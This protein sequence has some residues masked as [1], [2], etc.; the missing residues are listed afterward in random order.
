MDVFEGLGY[1]V[2]C[3]DMTPHEYGAGQS[4]PRMYVMIIRRVHGVGRVPGVRDPSPSMS[5]CISAMRLPPRDL[6]SFVFRNDDPRVTRWTVKHTQAPRTKLEENLGRCVGS[7]RR[8]QSTPVP[9]QV[10]RSDTRTRWLEQHCALYQEAGLPWPGTMN[11]PTVAQYFASPESMESF[12]VLT[13]RE[14]DAL[15]YLVARRKLQDLD[16]GCTGSEAMVDLY[17]SLARVLKWRVGISPCVLPHSN[18]WIL[19]ARR[20]ASPEEALLLQDFDLEAF[21]IVPVP[22]AEGKRRKRK[23]PESAGAAGSTGSAGSEEQTQTHEWGRR[24]LFDLAGNAFNGSCV[25][26]CL[27]TLLAHAGSLE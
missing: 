8:P 4:R 19:S 14:Q 26:A 15:V 22:R 12:A 2:H 7:A 17:H 6:R 5:F 10:L 24:F 25:A 1:W 27:L 3:Q 23:R 16:D 18:I 21:G 20:L 11:I 13:E 9:G